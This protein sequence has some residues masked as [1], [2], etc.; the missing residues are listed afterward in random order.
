MGYLNARRK[1]RRLLSNSS[2]PWRTVQLLGIALVTLLSTYA[3]AVEAATPS[4]SGAFSNFLTADSI[5]IS[6]LTLILLFLAVVI[7]GY[8]IYSRRITPLR[9]MLGSIN[10]VVLSAR[11]GD[12]AGRARCD[13]QGELGQIAT[14]LNHLMDQLQDGVNS[15][16]KDVCKLT[17]Y[18][19]DGQ[20][21]KLSLA[22]EVVEALV[23]VSQFKQQI[24][25]DL[26]KQEVY[27]RISSIISDRFGIQRF[28]I[29]EVS[30]SQNRMHPVVVNGTLEGACHWCQNDIQF[31]AEFCRAQRTGHVVDGME[32]IDLCNQFYNAEASQGELNYLCIPVI[33]SGTVGN[34]VQLVVEP[35][36]GAMFRYTIPFLEVFLRE[37]SSVIESKRLTEKLRESALKDALTGLNNRRFL[38]EYIH[39]IVA[40]AQ[41]K[42]MVLSILMM[43]LDHFKS[44]ND[45]Y[46]HQVGDTVLKALAGVLRSQVR[47]SDL[48][49][50]YG[51]E[52]FM[53]VLQ[54]EEVN[55]G[56]V[57]AEKI[58]EAVSQQKISIPGGT[59]KKTISIGVAEFPT[60]GTEFNDVVEKADMALYRAKEQGRDQVVVHA[61]PE[62]EFCE[63]PK[64]NSEESTESQEGSE[65][66]LQIAK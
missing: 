42:N 48:V 13:C 43:D 25:E 12:F 60:D 4:A 23:S 21:N 27:N 41:R 49:V 7:V 14:H 63:M 46:G 10:K 24:E 45:T 9:M 6:P 36:F 58:R 39:T 44:V 20:T 35:D 32:Q 34:V 11:E 31:R 65:R 29:Y 33:H 50:R 56:H 40:G 38:E 37:S 26:T 28:T 3:M 8:F 2:R 30:S 18:H 19:A 53:I 15:I 1:T 52:E 54:N 5:V 51:G 55:Q 17:Q 64:A 16:N 62:G 47:A 59:L 61:A 22:V 57:L 66:V